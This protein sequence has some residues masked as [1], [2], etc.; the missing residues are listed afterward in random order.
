MSNSGNVLSAI[1]K[2]RSFWLMIVF[3]SLIVAVSLLYY[4]LSFGKPIMGTTL[5]LGNTGWTV[6]SV[7]ANGIA[8]R[9][10][11]RV[12]DVP[13]KV[14][15]EPA[16][17]FL[18]KYLDQK[19]VFSMAIKELTVVDSQGIIV[20]ASL[21][22]SK[23]PIASYF[24]TLV[25]LV[26]CLIFWAIGFFVY[27]KR[28]QSRAAL[29][30][31]SSSLAL[32]LVICTNIGA[33]RSIPQAYRLT[34]IAGIF[35]PWVLT[36][37]FIVLPE[38]KTKLQ[39]PL[40][41]FLI[42]LIPVVL[43]I[44]SIFKGFEDGQALSWFRVVRLIEYAIGF[45]VL[46]SVAIYNFVRAASPKSRQQMKIVLLSCLAALIPFFLVYLIPQITT[47]TTVVPAGYLVP[48]LDIIPLGMGYAII[49]TKLLD[50]DI[51]LRRGAI[52][53]SVAVVMA[54][55]LGAA[56]VPIILSTNKLNIFQALLISLILGIIATFPFG[57]LRKY[58]ENLIDRFFYKDRYDYKQIIQALSI[59]LNNLQELSDMSR[60]VVGA[61]KRTLNLAGASLYLKK[62]NSVFDVQASEGIFSDPDK[63]I[64]ILTLVYQHDPQIDFPNTAHSANADLSYFIPLKNEKRTFGYLALSH[65][66]NRQVFSSDDIFLLQG[67][68][69]VA[70]TALNGAMLA[71]DVS[72]RDNFVSIASHELRTPLTSVIGYTDLLLRRNPPEELRRQWLVNIQDNGQKIAN[73][74]DDLLNVTRI[75]S[76]KYDLKISE[77]N[78]KEVT[79]ERLPIIKDSTTIHDFNL[80]I[81]V[82]LPN[83]I[84]DKDKLGQILNNLLS[85][86]VKYSPMGGMINI[87]AN[88]TQAENS[89]T[90]AISDE[91]M[92]ISE[93]DK[94]TLFKTFHRIQRPEMRGIRGSGLGLYIVKEWVDAMGGRVW[95]SS[96]LNKGSTFYFSLPAVNRPS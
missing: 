63:H 55:I 32:G 10:G 44:L 5:S 6:E 4:V 86:A 93:D 39:S 85:N 14:N 56:I 94:S 41:I 43:S 17:Q 15:G 64:Q 1:N 76:G 24:E 72:L 60:L 49:T 84:A 34:F 20:S 29:L 66:I 12:G 22:N 62:P 48:L 89:V 78:L 52:Y 69:S 40:F 96:T 57:V 91:G 54:I 38:E 18:S 90:I 53:I 19:T 71:H 2:R 7:D 31:L 9:S 45:I 68:A 87:R 13:I 77:V 79:N 42:Y 80:D 26:T 3:S 92:G 67:V 59:S 58:I 37:F 25:L 47:Q 82:D 75:Q 73:L 65:K 70:T 46:L 36:H 27:F 83:L 16:D 33:E 61:C 8:A 50:I 23:P 74:V 21:F 81:P 95:L 88:Y 51:L 11:I 30:L 28:P 35:G